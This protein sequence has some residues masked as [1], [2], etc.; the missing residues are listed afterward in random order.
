[1]QKEAGKPRPRGARADRATNMQE[2]LGYLRANG[3]A[4]QADI[5]R[6]TT[7][8]R[9]TVNQIVR[10][11]RDQGSVEYQ[12][13]NRR[14]AL[15]SLSSTSG[16]VASIIVRERSVHA[17]LFDFTAQKRFDLYSSEFPEYRDTQTSP[18]MVLGLA[19]R[20]I[21]AANDRGS[22]L[23][24]FA[25]A[26]EG[27]V[28]RKSGAIAPWAWQRLPHWKQVDIKQT[29]SKQLRLPVVVDN[30]ANLAALAEWTWGVG[31]GSTDF[32]YITCSE[33]IG[34]GF[35]INGRIYHG[36]TGLAGEIGHMVIE[37]AGDLC[38]CGSRGCLT[39]FSTE[40]AI[41]KAL[42]DS[43]KAKASLAEVIESAKQGDAACHRVLSEA[44]S[45]LGK[46]L[47]TV[48]RVMGPSV[49][50]I[51]GVLGTAGDIVLR[52]L[53]S[54]AEVMNLRNIG[55][56]PDIRV[57]SILEHATELGGLAAT[58]S[59]LDLGMS[60]LTPWMLSPVSLTSSVAATTKATVN[61]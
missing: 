8:A 55:E 39:S 60:S 20:L 7:L 46:A 53:R 22:P 56:A 36:G 50:A 23:I 41:L 33:G 9:A 51:G 16:S 31:R 54:S 43:G 12:W 19:N 27:P 11:L 32:L 35:V 57:A 28:E 13:K 30:D 5:S 25:L 15:V 58:L 4:T 59:E 26:M 17:I 49:I 45:H 48:V 29:L 6:A 1:M 61:A 14:E 37:D 10:A 2:I 3:P 44:G 42:R 38:F 24:G 52:G 21:N 18:A 47:A 40:R 34:G